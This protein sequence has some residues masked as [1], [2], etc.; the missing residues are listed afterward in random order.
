MKPS[1]CHHREPSQ[2]AKPSIR[3]SLATNFDPEL[4]SQVAPFGVFELYGKL[5]YDVVGGGRAGYMLPRVNRR[6]LAR[7]V[8]ACREAGL[9]FNY[10]LNALCLNNEEYTRRGQRRIRQL[11]DW[12]GEIGVRSVTVANPFLLRFIKRHYPEFEVRVSVFTAVNDIRRVR[13]WEDLGADRITLDSIQVNR[14]FELLARIRD[15][16][17]V[18]LELLASNSCIQNCPLQPYHPA[19]LAHASQAGHRRRMVVDWCLMWCSYMKIKDPSHYLRA[20]WIRPEDLKYYEAL[21]YHEF[22]LTERNAPTEILVLRAKAYWSRRYDGNLL[23]LVQPYGYPVEGEVQQRGLGWVLRHFT[24]P[25]GLRMRDLPQLYRLARLR[26]FLGG[27]KAPVYV[28]NRKLDGFI[29]RFFRERCRDRD[30]D[31]CGYCAAWAE[32]VVQ[33][34]PRWREACLSMYQWFFERYEGGKSISD[35]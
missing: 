23:D 27:G 31:E 11:L 3:F 8:E 7:H 9:Q 6:H 30:C 19:F 22:K 4:P 28:D 12:I 29:E 34:D 24:R 18:R 15:H 32:R 16:V 21:G 14:D 5:P 26:G 20:D 1:E 17:S 25:G 33:M 2:T 35:I 13:Y 10:L